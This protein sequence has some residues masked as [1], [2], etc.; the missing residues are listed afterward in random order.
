MANKITKDEIAD[1]DLFNNIIDGAN[2]AIKKIDELNAS[3]A[4][5]GSGLKESVS[6]IKVDDIKG[7]KELLTI[8]KESE[9]LARE[10]IKTD[11]ELLDLANKK[12]EAERKLSAISQ[13][14]ANKISES[15]YCCELLRFAVVTSI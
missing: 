13:S 15:N 9:R 11:K 4:S 10:K 8:S 7:I 6:K 1:K 12:Q 3:F 14:T 5:I 2:T